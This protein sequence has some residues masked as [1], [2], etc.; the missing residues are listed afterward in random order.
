VQ[1]AGQQLS[2]EPGVTRPRMTP[3][4][5]QTESEARR[6]IEQIRDVMT[7]VTVRSYDDGDSLKTSADRLE[8]ASRDLASALRELARERRASAEEI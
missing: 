4:E 1:K 7:I 2:M 5:R 6:L 8:L 3:A